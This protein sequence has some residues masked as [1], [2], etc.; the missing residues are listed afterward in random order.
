MPIQIIDNIPT[1]AYDND[2]DKFKV[3]ASEL[4]TKLDSLS[5]LITSI[6]D[7]GGIKKIT[8]VVNTQLT[9]STVGEEFTFQDAVIV[10]GEGEHLTLSGQD[11]VIVSIPTGTST[12]RTIVFKATSLGVVAYLFGSKIDSF[13][14]INLAVSTT[15][16]NEVWEIEGLAGY[17]DFFCEVTAV[18]GGNVTVKGR[19]VA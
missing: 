10:T 12:S 18:V 7:T 11:K 15:G 1:V 6:K 4:E 8:D 14:N 19:L 2:L 13:G 17:D 3:K 9:G 16:Q 5:S